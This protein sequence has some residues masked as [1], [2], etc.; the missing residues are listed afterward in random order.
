MTRLGLIGSLARMTRSTEPGY[1]DDSRETLDRLIFEAR[2]LVR[3]M[4]AND[5]DDDDS[6]NGGRD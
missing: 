4:P 3:D 1:N 5:D 2:L 6:T